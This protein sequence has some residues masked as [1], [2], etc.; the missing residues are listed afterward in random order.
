MIDLT[1]VQ[2]HPVINEITDVL[3]NKTQNTDRGFFNVEVAYFLGKLASSQRATI[4]TKDRGEIPVNIYAMNLATSGYGK[5]HSVAIFEGQFLT[6][7]R[8][9]FME[10]TFPIVA[11]KHLW[12]IANERA[13]RNGTDQQEEFEKAEAEWK[14]AGALPFTFDSATGPAVKQLRHKLVM[15]N[16]GSLN[17]QVDE[18]GTNLQA[19]LEPL[20][21][22][23][24]LY[25]QGLIKPKLTKNT[26]ENVRNEDL[27][28]KTPANMLLFGTPS[29]LFD[30]GPTEDAFYSLLDTGYARRCFFGWGQAEKKAHLSLTPAEI[31][32]DLVNP[33][34][35][36]VVDKWA[37]HF[38]SLADPAV[39]GWKMKVEDDVGIMLLT[40]QI[41]CKKA[42]DGMA[43]H[44]EIRKAE[45][46]HRYF[47]ALKLAGAYA[48]VD[49]SLEITMDHLKQA[50]LL[51]EESGAA[52]QKILTREKAYV[53]LARYIVD[54]GADLTHADLHEALPF[55]KASNAARNELM[56]MAVA[57][58]YTRNWIIKKKFVDGIEFFRGEK[59]KETNLDEM[60]VAYSDH[61]AYN[62][63]NE[64]VPFDQL[65]NLTQAAGMHWTNHHFK[66]GHRSAENVIVGFNMVI[67]D[68]DG[69]VS[70]QTVHGLMSEYKFMTYTTKRHRQVTGVDGQGNDIVGED[71]FRL[72]LPMNFH[73]ELDRE[74]YKA[75]MNSVMAWLPFPTDES[76]NQAEKKWECF[77]GGT[78]HRNDEGGLLDILPFIPRTSMNDKFQAGFKAIESLDNLERWFAGRIASGN[79]NNQMIKFALALVDN[80]MSLL[81]VSRQVHAFN[82]KISNPMDEDEIDSTI[83][84]TVAKK[85]ARK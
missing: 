15:S 53:K 67:I 10:D 71:R 82:G 34:N 20:A 59:L 38:H 9:R 29:K 5:G 3:C 24:E 85:F 41:E 52:F 70:L 44:E 49:G 58:G 13:V 37:Q 76:A 30:G 83:L 73:L 40:Y 62:Y 64:V 17:L 28:G 22:Y 31:Y 77:E 21:L 72:I 81:E 7:F 25:D 50:I 32:A 69:G 48:F 55:Y 75:F 8:K 60:I 79:R 66:G 57:A 18:V 12:D 33:T 43:D 2:H 23:L 16:C 19:A 74:D 14:R 6:G 4:V 11:E 26:A 47:K 45:M 84:V 63:L 46:E 54:V 42:A 80:G 65:D 36:A 56:T 27:D 68:V 35:S 78:F 39:F 61:W 1:G 51:T